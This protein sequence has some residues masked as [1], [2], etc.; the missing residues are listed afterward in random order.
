MDTPLGMTRVLCP[1][2]HTS[3]LAHCLT[4]RYRSPEGLVTVQK[5]G[6]VACSHPL[7]DHIWTPEP[8]TIT[9]PTN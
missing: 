7:C 4:S 5:C 1:E 8:K 6:T 2:C 9:T 3:Q